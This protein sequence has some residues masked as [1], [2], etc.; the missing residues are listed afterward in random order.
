MSLGDLNTIVT[1]PWAD[2]GLVDSGN[3]RKFERYGRVRV[4]RPEPQAMWPPA[5]AA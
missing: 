2:F 3:G 5:S 1:E 4:I